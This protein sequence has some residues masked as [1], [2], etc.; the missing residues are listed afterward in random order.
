MTSFVLV[1]PAV[2]GDR[3]VCQGGHRTKTTDAR[4][5]A[6]NLAA[7]ASA[8][9]FLMLEL[10]VRA[11]E[12][13]RLASVP[14]VFRNGVEIGILVCHIQ[15]MLHIV[16]KYDHNVVSPIVVDLFLRQPGY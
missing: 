1:L 12:A 15:P 7:S 3:Q 4:Q 9:Q 6:A 14:V 8:V 13:A 5:A 2:T 10:P 11:R 16:E